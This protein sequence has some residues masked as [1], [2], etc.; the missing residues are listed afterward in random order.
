MPGQQNVRSDTHHFPYRPPQ[1][2]YPSPSFPQAACHPQSTATPGDLRGLPCRSYRER[3]LYPLRRCCR[4]SPRHPA[5]QLVP[6]PQPGQ[7]P[8]APAGPVRTRRAP[9]TRGASRP[10]PGLRLRL[11]LHRSRANSRGRRPR[12]HS[13][14]MAANGKRAAAHRE[15]QRQR[16][17]N[18]RV[19]NTPTQSCKHGLPLL[20]EVD[21]DAPGGTHRE[22]DRAPSRRRPQRQNGAET[23]LP[24]APVTKPPRGPLQSGPKPHDEGRRRLGR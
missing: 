3:L 1:P 22:N 21:D 14:T 7:S 11:R 6:W 4:R 20:R 24:R 12:R 23:R 16:H 19:S 8:I 18:V 17:T 13:A 9:R 5:H 15:H 10:H 2:N